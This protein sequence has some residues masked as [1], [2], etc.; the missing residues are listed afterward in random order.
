MKNPF[1]S[2]QKEKDTMDPKWVEM[3]ELAQADLLNLIDSQQAS[4]PIPL[5]DTI[6]T[7]VTT[8]RLDI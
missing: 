5:G 7:P 2:K 8:T 6:P 3:K 1:K 4:F